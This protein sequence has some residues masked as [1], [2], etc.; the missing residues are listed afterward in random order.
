[1]LEVVTLVMYLPV[2]MTYF[3]LLVDGAGWVLWQFSMLRR[4]SDRGKLDLLCDVRREAGRP[5]AVLVPWPTH[6][7]T[8]R[9]NSLTYK[10]ELLCVAVV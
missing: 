5:E 9:N 2:F 7:Y 1:M 3:R 8:V 6:K 4:K 10:S